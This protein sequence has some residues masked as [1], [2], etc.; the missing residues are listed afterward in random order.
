MPHVS[1]SVRDWSDEYGRAL[2]PIAAPPD[3]TTFGDVETS[4]LADLAAAVAAVSLGEI[5]RQAVTALDDGGNDVRP[6]SALAQREL[7]LRI[8]FHSDGSLEKRNITIP[9][10]DIAVLTIEGGTDLVTLQDAGPMAQMVAAIETY[11]NFDGS[12]VTV[13]RAVIVGRNS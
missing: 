9:C 7:G 10:V 13:D 11:V 4:T 8:F 3:L 12:S 6:A 5:A 2:F 1:F